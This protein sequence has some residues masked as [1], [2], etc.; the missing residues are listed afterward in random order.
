M[1]GNRKTS[2]RKKENIQP[3]TYEQARGVL[4]YLASVVRSLREH[5]LEALTH[6]RN[7]RAIADR[8]GRPVRATIIAQEEETRAASAAD[9]RFE[10]ALEELHQLDIY[11]LDP[12]RGEA[13]VPFVHDNQ[14]AW[15]I[16]DVFDEAP[17]RFWRYH[18]DPLE[19]RRPTAEPGHGPAGAPQTD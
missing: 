4:P 13:L 8:P 16:Y 2:K 12:V 6:H 5:R 19:A 1:N 17:Y 15:Y 14:L 18:T 11:C 9:E 7:A 10:A 3:W